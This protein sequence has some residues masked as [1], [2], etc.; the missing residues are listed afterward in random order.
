[1]QA[2]PVTWR[3]LIEA[4]WQGGGLKV[5]CGGEALPRD[6][7]RQLVKRSPSVWNL[8][9][10]TETTIWSSIFQVGHEEQALVPIGRPIANTQMYIL[11]SNLAPVSV[12]D[13]GELYIGGDG[14]ARGYLNRPELTAEKFVTNPFVPGTRMYRTGDVA[15]YLE[16][17]DIE[18]LGRM[19][20]QVK[21]RGF[22]I[23]LGEIEA[24]LEEQAG[25][26][27]AVVVAKTEESGEKRLVAYYVGQGEKEPRKSEL[28][29][30]LK[31]RLAEYMIPSVFVR[32]EALP[33][34]ANGK[35]DR[36]A[37]PE[38][39][40]EEEGEEESY[41]GVQDELQ[42]E[43]AK[44]WE[45]VLGRGS[46]GIRDNFF[47]LGGHS[48]LAVRVMN[49]MEQAFG[50]RLPVATLFQA[51]TVEQ[52]AGL[53][54]QE[55]WTPPWSSLVVIQAGGSNPPFFCV[56][57]VGG[58]VLGFRDL[59]R[60]LGPEQPVYGLQAQGLDGKHPCHRRVEDMAAHYIRE[61]QS[62][63]T[64]GPYYL[65]GLSFGGA[66][67]FEMAQ[68]LHAQGQEVG[69]VA[70]FDTFPTNYK[71][72]SSLII[73]FLLLP[74]RLK[75]FYLFRKMKNARRNLRR[76]ISKAFLPRELKN[77]RKACREAAK[78]YV[79]TVY[80]GRV[81]LFRASDKS[82]KTFDDLLIGW[83]QWVLGGLETHEVAG[84]H[85]SIIT[86]PQVSDL[87]RQ[88]KECL[89]TTRSADPTVQNTVVPSPSTL[90]LLLPESSS[91]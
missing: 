82:F 29:Q 41:V 66:V 23:E 63:Q 12:G 39:G 60:R 89:N 34:T 86:E 59:A 55:G 25:V 36:K 33:L 84:D 77:V 24:I 88:L 13:V 85:L 87:A 8:Y 67:A 61:I 80:P 38:P 72:N 47:D 54:R 3:L 5:I 19:D 57:D 48:L 44:I 37:L 18:F 14:L 75:Y 1:M 26:R 81:V 2:T 65:G 15:R 40:R 76:R 74:I 58:G 70:L 64:E 31:A 51:P 50:K 71:P 7:A 42:R 28:R 90:D 11:G 56:H 43:L 45:G 62:V 49:R 53:L 20:Q 6:L 46:I 52:L 35:V 4:G 68:Q 83:N 91:V 73:K 16:N 30:G 32:M 69:L 22:R 17:G 10:P 9:G 27:Q 21:I 78:S 79:P